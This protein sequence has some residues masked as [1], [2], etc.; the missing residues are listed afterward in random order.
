MLFRSPTAWVSGDIYDITRLDEEHV[1]F[2][3]ADVVGHGI[4]AALLTIFLKQ[5]M[6]MRETV[7]GSYKIYSPSDVKIGRASC[8]ERV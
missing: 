6:I 8:R 3:V 5:A 2:Y 4:P 1:G 7:G